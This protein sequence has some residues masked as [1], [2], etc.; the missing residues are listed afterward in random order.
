MSI[1]VIGAGF[2]RTGTLSLKMAL[3]QLTFT[4]CYHMHDLFAHPGHAETWTDIAQGNA[5]NWPVL[6]N[7]YRALV[8]WPCAYFW[9]ELSDYYPQAKI[10]LTVRDANAWY[11][12]IEQTIFAVINRSFPEGATQPQLPQNASPVAAAQISMAKL[13]IADSLFSGRLDD[14]QHC[15]SVYEQ[16]NAEVQR[17]IPAE[18]LLV[19]NVSEGWS[20][21]CKFLGT[22]EPD[23]AFP[24]S[25]SKREF[26]SAMD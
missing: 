19:Y 9:R 1:E 7:G 18:R 17:S 21:L 2:G 22:T 5:A 11:D 6:F 3:E 20:P 12:S 23:T 24:R 13:M 16:H 15:I 26:L 10:V 4:K 14:R 25:N 8:D